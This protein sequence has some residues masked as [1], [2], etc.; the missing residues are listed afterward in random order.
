[1]SVAI[2]RAFVQL[3]ETIAANK[4][5]AA[6]VEKLEHGHRQTGKVIEILVAEI[7]H[8]KALPEPATHQDRF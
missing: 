3:R 7:E 4:H 6:R 1:M 8:M 2:V 5:L